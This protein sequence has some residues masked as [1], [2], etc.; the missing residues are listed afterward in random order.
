MNAGDHPTTDLV[1]KINAPRDDDR[2][3]P[4]PH[5]FSLLEHVVIHHKYAS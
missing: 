2:E 5:R 3:P 1:T 4:A